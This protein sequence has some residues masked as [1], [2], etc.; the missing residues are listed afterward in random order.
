MPRSAGQTHQAQHNTS[1]PW[2]LNTIFHVSSFIRRHPEQQRCQPDPARDKQAKS[3]DFI[4][5]FDCR[6]IILVR[7]NCCNLRSKAILSQRHHDLPE[8]NLAAILALPPLPSPPVGSAATRSLASNQVAR[9]QP[10]IGP[11]A[12]TSCLL[13]APNVHWGT[14]VVRRRSKRT[15]SPRSGPWAVSAEAVSECAPPCAAR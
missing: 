13:W 4:G 7:R 3:L 14:S 15:R 5:V 12:R 2:L 8:S 10:D 6:V 1:A 9:A 11:G